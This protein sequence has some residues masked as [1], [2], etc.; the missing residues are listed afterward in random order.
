MAEVEDKAEEDDAED[1]D[2]EGDHP[3]VDVAVEDADHLEEDDQCDEREN[4]IS[5]IFLLLFSD[6]LVLYLIFTSS[7]VKLPCT[8]WL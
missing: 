8:H 2:G 1:V 3:E 5:R 7:D 6:H 4:L